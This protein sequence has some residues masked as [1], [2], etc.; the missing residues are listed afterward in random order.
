MTVAA[1]IDSAVQRGISILAI[2]DHN[3]DANIQAALDYALR[4]GDS[5]LLIPAVEITTAN[6]H[7]LAYFPPE[8][9]QRVRDLL[10]VL[11]LEG[12]M[13][14]RECHTPFS[15][16]S[17]IAEAEK[18]GA[19]CIAA[20]ID[21]SK[22][23]FEA[24]VSGYQNAKKDI[25][26]SPGLYGMEF[27][28]VTHLGWYSEDDAPTPDGGERKRLLGMREKKTA[29]AARIN[30]AALQNTDA[31][32]LQGFE[33]RIGEGRFTRLKMNDLS[34][35]AF[36]TALVDP[37]ARVRAVATIPKSFPRVLGM[38]VTGGFL[39]GAVIHFSSNLNC[40]IGGRGAG[41]STAI[42]SLAYGLGGNDEFADHDNCPDTIVVYAEDAD[43]V[44]Y[45]YERNRGRDVVVRAKDDGSIANVPP[46][47]FRVEFYAQGALTEVAKDPLGNPEAL[48]GFLDRHLTLDDAEAVESELVD[49]LAQNSTELIPLELAASQL[50]G[51]Q[52]EMASIAKKVEIA[53]AGKLKDFVAF[54]SAVSAQKA[55]ATTLVDLQKLYALPL[56]L[57][58]WR[59]NY[60]EMVANVGE[61]SDDARSI[62]VLGEVEALITEVNASTQ[63]EEKRLGVVF[64]SFAEKL[65]GLLGQLS[66][67]HKELDLQVSDRIADFQKKG[68]TGDLR[69]LNVLLNRR[70]LLSTD[71]ARISAQSINLQE[72]R[73]ARMALL[74]RL[75]DVRS[76][77]S[78]R[79]KDQLAVINKQLRQTIDDYNINL[80]YDA[81]GMTRS[82][83][84]LVSDVM[85][86]TYMQDDVIRAGCEKIS[87]SDLAK[88][89]RDGNEGGIS[90]VFGP[91]WG[92][93]VIN[94]FRELRNLHA[95]E[96]V[97]KPDKPVIKILTRGTPAKQIP[98]NQLSDGQKHT[99]L[100]TIA[101]LADSHL[102]LVID[103]PED[104][105]D[106][107]FIF[108]SVVRTLR[109]IKERRQV[110]VVTHNANIA[111]L[112][113]SE[114]ILPLTRS[115]VTATINERGSVDRKK[116][117][118]VVQNILEGGQ[119]AFQRRKE[120]YGH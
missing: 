91:A 51:K 56:S 34:F 109:S 87:P 49:S 104:D 78:R 102:P 71:I 26:A 80:Y 79:R 23:G 3:T 48:Q 10:G 93:P 97:A 59:R 95:L 5:L 16:A 24:L 18:L 4:H 114:L 20:H 115:D 116:T 69:G 61:I 40:F 117:S 11:K 92:V 105:L 12:E 8:Y 2:T 42:Q 96:I 45:R 58:K 118:E 17:A 29:T 111:V 108:S 77:L 76:Q 72:T 90:S 35:E 88:H 103:Q 25:L 39:D 44:R 41:K 86:G 120:I 99:I 89:V 75:S 19:V 65:G 100:L 113:D 60:A 46:D 66:A 52:L 31:H 21:R 70:T 64:S 82:F 15:M 68:L 43:G 30:L 38:H 13:G 32:D 106:N 1:I 85:H 50:K 28:E 27:D 67:R 112:G 119:V 81:S 7:L 47:S 62:A 74:E 110:L 57:S 22:T 98:A 54:Q 55:L 6:G 63:A 83:C 36:R 37:E 107:A 84:A 33:S 73:S 53:E 94:K 14:T 9:P 101:L